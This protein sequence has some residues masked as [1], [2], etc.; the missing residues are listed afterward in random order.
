MPIGCSRMTRVRL[1]DRPDA[2]ANVARQR[3][4][5]L[6]DDSQTCY[7]GRVMLAVESLRP[8]YVS[9][10]CEI[11]LARREL[12]IAGSPVP[13]GGRAFEIVEILVQSAGELV[14]KRELIDRIWPDVIVNDNALQVHISAVRKALGSHRAMLK[15]ESGRGYRLLG[16]WAIRDHGPVTAPADPSQQPGSNGHRAAHFPLNIISV[17]GRSSDIDRLRD[18]LSAYRLVT[19]AGPGGIGKTVLALETSRTISHEFEDGVWLVELGSL[20]DPD[21]MPSAVAGTLGLRLN[22]GEIST[23]AVAHAIGQKALLLILDNCEHII[24]A[25]ADLAETFIRF[26][27][28][29]TLLVT[30]REVLRVNGECVYR[31][32]PLDVPAVGRD[33]Q[34]HILG[35][36]A[37]ELFVAR[38]QALDS[39][40]SPRAETLPAIATIC[41]H[42][43]GIP[44][45]IEFA[46]ARAATLGI[47]QVV[48]GLNDRFGLLTSGR[49]TSLP[50]HRTLR[51]ALDWS[52]ELLSQE[53]QLSLRRLAVFPAGF[54]LGGAAAVLGEAAGGTLSPLDGIANLLAK[55]LLTQDRSVSGGRWYLLETIRAYALE[56]AAEHD[57]VNAAARHHASYFRELFAPDPD[58]G[59]PLSNE[60]LT[61][62]VREIDNVRAALDWSFSPSGDG[63]IGIDLTVAYAP[64]W[65]NLSL[66]TE[67]R[68]RCERALLEFERDATLSPQTRM[69]LQ[70]ALGTSLIDTMGQVEQA[71]TLLA[72][73]LETADALN[74][75]DAQARALIGLM[76]A[77]LYHGLHGRARTAVRRF[78]E[79]AERLADPAVTLVADRLMATMLLTIG[80]FREAHHAL[81]RVLQFHDPPQKR[82]RALWY[83]TGHRA[84]DRAMLSRALWLRGFMEQA[85]RE[86]Q[87]SLDELGPMDPQLLICRVLYVGICRL[88]PMTGDFATAA[89]TNARLIEVAASLNAQRWQTVGRFL[90][91]KLMVERGD[92]ANG[93]AALRD[94][95]DTCRRTGWLMSYPEYKC[96]LAQALAGLGQLD[97]ALEAVEEGL[98]GSGQNED[99][100]RWYVPELLRTKGEV[101][102]QG[103]MNRSHA[104]AEDCFDQA[105]A[106][107]REQG[108]LFWELRVA[109]S[110][111]R[112]RMAQRRN[113]EARQVLA[114]VYD[115]FT[116]G[117]G[118]ADM[119]SARQLLDSLSSAKF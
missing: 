57:E 62:R 11:D 96:W 90:E 21:L 80:S 64:V 44:L 7:I 74:D 19:L 25:V 50:R 27:A 38:T 5:E 108:A 4:L 103:A 87:A 94:A 79:I 86:A 45:A 32:P 101:L 111:A 99:G 71:R 23:D 104:L 91:G 105:A 18:L 53:E 37:V 75:L 51:A 116:E 95:F 29:V 100:Q 84:S 77:S 55:S 24:D 118:T 115:R 113:N 112:L 30:S 114:P 73:A 8:I 60:D 58:I 89:Q 59:S 47:H 16:D 93:L 26:C 85:H 78:G 35:C 61:R 12:R 119:R 28:G 70:I 110:L 66:M 109:L 31:V 22:G 40:F 1:K 15:T 54:T 92:F 46:A 82:W 98:E 72:K 106:L 49:R 13:V 76:T 69:W 36:S 14:R 65:L 68:E 9:G 42:L 43:D 17:I 34:E 63:A 83:P 41:R 56:K 39:D 48:A 6:C 67:C 97:E 81:E 117:F 10:G 3:L 52:Y 2:A 88:A 107:A 33:D 20:A 102:L